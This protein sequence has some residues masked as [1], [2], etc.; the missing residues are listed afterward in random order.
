MHQLIPRYVAA[1]LALSALLAAA[2][3]VAQADALSA[4]QTL[5]AG[6]CGGIVPIAKPLRH[7]VLLDRTAQQWPGGRPLGDLTPE[8][9]RKKIH[10][11]P[12]SRQASDELRFSGRD[13]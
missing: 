1:L 8:R 11:N 6:G 13:L 12:S 2:A 3:P 4:V 10:R 7:E 9:R 5:R